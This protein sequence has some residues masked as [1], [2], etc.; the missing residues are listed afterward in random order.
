MLDLFII[1][2]YQKNSQPIETVISFQG[3]LSRFFIVSCFE[4]I[5]EIEKKEDWYGVFYDDEVISEELLFSLELFFA[6]KGHDVLVALKK[7]ITGN[8]ISKSPR[9]FKKELTLKK[10]CLQPVEECVYETILDGWIY[11]YGFD[12]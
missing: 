12:V 7:D 3:R 1:D 9:F 10:D 5:N 6:H 8:R 11:E 4:E 2:A